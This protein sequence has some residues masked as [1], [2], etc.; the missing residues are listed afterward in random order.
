VPVNLPDGVTVIT[1]TLLPD[2]LT[3]I[4]SDTLLATDMS[5]AFLQVDSSTVEDVTSQGLLAAT[6]YQQ[7]S[8]HLTL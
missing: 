2:D 4:K 1:I 7:L 6:V 3:A 5:N 8:Y